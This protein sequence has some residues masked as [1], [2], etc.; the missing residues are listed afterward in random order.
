MKNPQKMDKIDV[1]VCIQPLE[2]KDSIDPEVLNNLEKS[3]KIVFGDVQILEPENVPLNTYNE[4]RGQYNSTMILKRL[5][6]SC[7]IT[8]GVMVEDIYPVGFNFVFGE[9]E[10]GGRR[11]LISIHRLRPEYY[12]MSE[13]MELLSL[14][15]L[16]EAVHEIGH[17]IGLKHCENKYCV[18]HFSNTINDTDIK[19]WE[20]CEKCI[21][22]LKKLI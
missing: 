4:E 17:V 16:K 11:A 13:D 20:Y 8:L 1:E 21:R 14:R 9:A 3:L 19:G 18:M 7:R 2:V 15:T 6:S 12:G 22:V 5:D 10:I